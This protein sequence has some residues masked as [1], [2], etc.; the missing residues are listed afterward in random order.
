MTKTQ[1]QALLSL[2]DCGETSKEVGASSPVS[3]R[4]IVIGDNG[5]VWVADVHM[6]GRYIVGENAR[7][8]IRYGTTEALGQ[9][10]AT[11]QTSETKFGPVTRILLHEYSIVGLIDVAKGVK[12]G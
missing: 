1:I 9:L 6:E 3:G 4:K 5:F 7:M 11:G 2:L 10:A 8:I 12:C